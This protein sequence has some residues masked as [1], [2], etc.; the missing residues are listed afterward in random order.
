MRSLLRNNSTTD[1]NLKGALKE[2]K[3]SY[4]WSIGSFKSALSEVRIKEYETASYDLLL[5]ATDCIHNCEEAVASKRIKDGIIAS[6]NKFA[7]IFGLTA[8]EA[9]DRI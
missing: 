6:G 1:L 4:D 7:R 8:F 3:S 9:V 5:A 2:C